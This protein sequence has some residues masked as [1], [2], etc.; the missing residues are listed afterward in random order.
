MTR[1]IL[2]TIGNLK[3]GE[4]REIELKLAKILIR[5]NFAKHVIKSKKDE[6]PN[7]N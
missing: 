3:K 7:N 2:K 1:E 6:Q 5:L 4:K